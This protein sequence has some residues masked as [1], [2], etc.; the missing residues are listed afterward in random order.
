[1]KLPEWLGH[2]AMLALAALVLIAV[3]QPIYTDDLWWHL[4]LGDSYRVHG[5][6]LS[7]DPVLYSA[8]GPPLPASWLADVGLAALAN[9]MGALGLRVAH[10]LLALSILGLAWS[11]FERAS[12]SRLL[13]SVGMGLFAI[14]AAYRLFQLRPHLGTML[15]ALALY[16]LLIEPGA[17]RSRWKLAAAGVLL[18]IWANV[19]AGFL[20]GLILPGVALASLLVALPFRPEEL[21]QEDRQRVLYLA[22]GLAVGFLASFIN[23]SGVLPHLAYFA[24]GTASPELARVGD[25]WIPFTLLQ[26]PRLNLPPSPISWA[27]LWA[28]WICAPVIAVWGVM[29][30]KQRS[31]EGPGS[32]LDPALMGLAAISLI[33]SLLAVRFLW[34]GIFPLLLVAHGLRV[35]GQGRAM[36][37]RS[38]GRLWAV[39]IVAVLLVPGF[40]RFGPWPMISRGVPAQWQAYSYPYPADKYFAHAVW[41][42]KDSGLEGNL[43]NNY[44]VGSF[45]SYWLPPK[46]KLFVNG[47]LNVSPEAMD[48]GHALRRRQGVGPEVGFLEL[49]D[50]EGVDV[51]FGV[52]L[53][54]LPFPN[55]PWDYTTGHLE[56]APGWIKV[57]RNMHS[58]VYLRDNERN[59]ANLERVARYYAAREVPFDPDAGFDPA[60][61]IREDAGWA[62]RQGLIPTYFPDLARFSGLR[63]PDTH[64]RTRNRLASVYAVLGLYDEAIAID[65][66]LLRVDPDLVSPGRRLVWSL[67][68]SD[69]PEEALEAARALTQ[70]EDEGELS[71]M[72]A[73]KAERYA[74]ETDPEARAAMRSTLPLF[75]HSEARL[76]DAGTV[77]AEPRPPGG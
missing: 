1:M 25:E 9:G 22:L 47:S 32:C 37:E 59:R 48:T 13:A 49:L 31:A 3:G 56:N 26:W 28:L 66:R 70:Q 62:T 7:E 67:I 39:A 57:F 74:E 68:R 60:S 73:K 44:S 50:R 64:R 71:R 69:R 34:L 14:L 63:D 17:S 36:P 5:P 27:I 35:G 52:R 29:R 24:A 30:W 2:A 61:V 12:H 55:R 75:S 45:A 77:S 65:R 15:A 19:H 40:L 4:A 11:L 76:L 43:F 42:M 23:P 10:V 6:W 20:L 53:P 38:R 16:R 46:L 72:L 21:R 41:F 18:A 51:F 33:A 54:H 58:S 8:L